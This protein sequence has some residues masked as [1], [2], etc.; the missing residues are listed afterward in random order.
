MVSGIRNDNWLARH[1][2]VR[3]YGRLLE[4]GIE[5]LEYNRTMLHHKTMVVDG[6]W[7]TIGTTNFDNRSFAHNEESNVCFFDRE[8]AAERTA[9]VPR[10]SRRLRAGRP[11][12]RGAAA[13]S[14]ARLQEFVASFLQ[15][16][17]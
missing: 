12:T 13:A 11:S 7:A 1:N 4:A 5:I 14:A 16:Q 3:L 6:V 15:E 17:V 10:R 2:S 9:D 8:L